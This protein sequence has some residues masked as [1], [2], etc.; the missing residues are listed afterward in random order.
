MNDANLCKV[1]DHCHIT[2]QYRGAAC[3]HCNLNNIN[4]IA[5]THTIPIVFH[6]LKGYDMHHILRN[7][8]NQYTNIIAT[9]TEKIIS[10]KIEGLKYIDSLSFLS[11]SL[12]TLAGNLPKDEF[13]SVREYLQQRLCNSQQPQSDIEIRCVE[14]A[15]DMITRKGVYPCDW[16][17]DASKLQNTS[18][19]P[20]DCFYSKLNVTNITDDEHAKREWEFFSRQTFKDYHELN[21][22]TD[23]LLLTDVFESFRRQSLESYSLDPACYISLP[24]LAWD[25]MLLKTGV[26]LELLSKEKSDIYLMVEQGIRGGISVAIKRHAKADEN[27][28]LMYLDANNL[29]GWAMS[30]PLPYGGFKMLDN[31]Q[32][33]NVAEILSNHNQD[34]GYIFKVDLQYPTHLHDAHSDLPLAPERLKVEEELLSEFQAKMHQKLFTNG[35]YKTTPKLIPNLYDK[36]GYIIHGDAL[37]QCLDLGLVL[38]K[39]H[40]IV[41]FKQSTWLKDYID[42]NTQKRTNA[43]NDFEKDFFK[44]MNNAVFGKTMEN[45]RNHITYEICTDKEQLIRWVQNPI[46]YGVVEINENTLFVMKKKKTVTLR[47][48]IYVGF[49]IQDIRKNLLYDFHYKFAKPNLPNT[50]LCYM[51]TDSFIYHIPM[52]QDAVNKILKEHADKFDFSNYDKEHENYSTENK[53]VVGKMKDE[54]GGVAME[55]FI[56]LRSKMYSCKIKDGVGIKK[57]KDIK[58]NVVKREIVHENYIESLKEERIFRHQQ[59]NI[60]S[61]GATH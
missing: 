23:V 44:L 31:V 1:K 11:S 33:V 6:N 39:V 12:A 54:L 2:G 55:E 46:F 51:D 25:A 7:L 61:L 47:K 13:K 19:P 56:G 48:P 43:K 28:T 20:K 4:I 41:E 59:R 26:S 29:Y 40:N 37:R 24:G 30:Q 10:A 49:S 58:K 42:F 21:L 9:S 3:S 45:V 15:F 36:K 14:E 60:E 52:P 16:M 32:N 53:K 35:K 17:N 38:T 18:L 50:Q 27:N 8:D 57:G 34:I 22:A 5:K